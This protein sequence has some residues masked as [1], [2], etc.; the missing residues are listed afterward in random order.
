LQR[1]RYA[2]LAPGEIE[3]IVASIEGSRIVGD[4]WLARLR[5]P[6]SVMAVA[7]AVG[8]AA[9]VAL[10]VSDKSEAAVTHG[11]VM[12]DAEQMS[13]LRRTSIVSASA[14][15]DDAIRDDSQREHATADAATIVAPAS[16]SAAQQPSRA[17]VRVHVP[18]ATP[19]VARTEA[20]D[21]PQVAM[22]QAASRAAS[23]TVDPGRALADALALCSEEPFL[24]RPSCQERARARYCDSAAPLP[25]CVVATREYGQ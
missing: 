5:T 10:H 16:A 17:A 24:A 8:V 13:R 23:A 3:P 18:A 6:G 20:G 21:A 2:G 9:A 4:H 19:A 22:Q 1:A 11:S 25:Q 14:A 7:F 12:L 15:A